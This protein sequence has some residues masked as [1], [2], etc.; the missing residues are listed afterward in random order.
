MSNVPPPPGVPGQPQLDDLVKLTWFGHPVVERTASTLIYQPWDAGG[1]DPF[2]EIGARVAQRLDGRPAHLDYMTQVAAEPLLDLPMVEQLCRTWIDLGARADQS[3]AVRCAGIL[4]GTADLEKLIARRDLDVPSRANALALYC[5]LPYAVERLCRAGFRALAEESAYDRAV[6]RPWMLHLDKRRDYAEIQRA[7]E[8]WLA[9]H[10]PS[11]GLMWHVYRGRLA[12]G[13]AMQGRNVEAWKIIEPE[14][15]TGQGSIMLWGSQILARLGRTDE[16]L[17]LARA[18]VE[19]YPDG[20]EQRAVLAELLWRA[21]RDSEAALA[22]EPPQPAYRV[23]E[24][25]WMEDVAQRFADVFRERPDARVEAAMRT[26]QAQGIYARK[27]SRLVP[28]LAAAGRNELAFRLLMSFPQKHLSWVDIAAYDKDAFEYLA[29]AQGRAAAIAWI[30]KAAVPAERESLLEALY[31]QRAYALLWD[32]VPAGEN[33]RL[34]EWIWLL[35][36]GA[37]AVDPA[38]A[39]AHRKDVAEHFR[40]PMPRDPTRTLAQYLLG[41]DDRETAARAATTPVDRCKAAYFFGLGE[42]AAG[43]Y[44]EAAEWHLLAFDGCTKAIWRMSYFSR[45]TLRRWS[46][47]GHNLR[48]AEARK[49]W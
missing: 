8:G 9:H 32:A 21:D 30:Q 44:R 18:S 28:P 27:L 36:A 31:D 19:R 22:L 3:W 24:G 6:T 5:D 1:R 11:F 42:V 37:V 33:A 35:R 17:Q 20:Y 12:H 2:P 39:A 41:M 38:V 25:F 23:F 45:T 29:K 4:S 26:L 15:S 43:R 49:I 48:E 16:A 34:S 13:L 10:D 7:A 14:L 47:D 40:D 46:T